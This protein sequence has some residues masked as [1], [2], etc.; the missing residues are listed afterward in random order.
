MAP[1][2]TLLRPDVH[3]K[4][5]DYTAETVPERETVAVVRRPHRDRRRSR[6]IIRRATC[7]PESADERP[8]RPARRARRHRPRRP[9]RGGA[10][11]RRIRTRGS[12][13]WSTRSTA[14][15]WISSPSVDRVVTLERRTLAGWGDDRA[16]AAAGAIRLGDRFS[17]AAEIGGAGAGI[18]RARAWRVSR[19]GICARKL[20]GPSTPTPGESAAGPGDPN[21]RGGEPRHSQESAASEGARHRRRS[22]HAFRWRR[23]SRR[24]VASVRATLGGRMSVRA[25]QS[26]RRV[27]EQAM[28]AGALWRGRG[29]SARRAASSVVR[30]VGAG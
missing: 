14:R 4:G 22:N 21:Q 19:S 23:P 16:N 5:T 11:A 6:R 10:A 26:R 8:H 29:V 1:L 25:D 18:R 7:C 9:G 3:C 28:A 30:V 13:G 20:P 12:T 27:A 2:L 15:S 24:A 17:G